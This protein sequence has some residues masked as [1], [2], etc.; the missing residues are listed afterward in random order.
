MTDRT[1]APTQTSPSTVEVVAMLG[2]S[3]L[4]VVHVE[5]K[6]RPRPRWSLYALRAAAVVFFGL[7][8]FAFLSGIGVAAENERALHAWTN[9]ER[10]PFREFRPKRSS[11]VHDWLALTAL[12]GGFLALVIALIRA[13][14]RLEERERIILACYYQEGLT[15]REIG[16]ILGVTESRVC[17]L[18]A[19]TLRTLRSQL[20]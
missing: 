13:R 5:P 2:D 12:G 4:D 11:A 9:V 8:G 7:A 1:H 10:R 17:Q 15:L 20:S 18:H 6:T 16:Q 19:Q 14:D 3:I